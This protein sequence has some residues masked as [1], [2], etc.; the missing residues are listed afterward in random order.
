[1]ARALFG[2]ELERAVKELHHQF[3]CLRVDADAFG[4]PGFE[5]DAT[6]ADMVRRSL[7][8]SRIPGADNNEVTDAIK[9]YVATIERICLPVLREDAMNETHNVH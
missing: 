3:W 5:N 7:W 8:N 6:Y 4:E 2:D 9:D 1:M